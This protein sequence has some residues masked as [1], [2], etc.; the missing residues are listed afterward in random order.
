MYFPSKL[1][2]PL[3]SKTFNLHGRNIFFFTRLLICKKEKKTVLYCLVEPM[4]GTRITLAAQAKRIGALGTRIKI[5]H[6][7]I[8]FKNSVMRSA[9]RRSVCRE[10]FAWNF[11]LRQWLPNCTHIFSSLRAV[12]PFRLLI[13]FYTVELQYLD[14]TKEVRKTIFLRHFMYFFSITWS[15]VADVLV[16]FRYFT[17]PK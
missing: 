5:N 14:Y 1:I 8:F 3:W 7:G 13:G 9:F 16:T 10:V 2:Y 6:Y 17:F 12:F 11:A 4:H 15:K